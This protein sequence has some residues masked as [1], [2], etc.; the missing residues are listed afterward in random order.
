MTRRPDPLEREVLTARAVWKDL[1]TEE[2]YI[3]Y[4][5]LASRLH[6]ERRV[7]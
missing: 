2:N 5:V 1:P 4:Q 3:R 7:A 6:R